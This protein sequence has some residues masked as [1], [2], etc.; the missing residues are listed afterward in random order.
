M[1]IKLLIARE[2]VPNHTNLNLCLAHVILYILQMSASEE[3]DSTKPE[4]CIEVDVH[5]SE[6]TEKDLSTSELDSLC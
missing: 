1:S 6:V 4:V 3:L 2:M 5:M